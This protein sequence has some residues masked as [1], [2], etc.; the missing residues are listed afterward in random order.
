[1]AGKARDP[2][3]LLNDV[4]EILDLTYRD[5]RFAAEPIQSMT[6]LSRLALSRKSMIFPSLSTYRHKHFHSPRTSMA[7]ISSAI[8]GR[9]RLVRRNSHETSFQESVL[10][11][12]R[13]GSEY[14]AIALPA[15]QR[16][17]LRKDGL[18]GLEV[19]PELV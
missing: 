17:N 11:K 6:A 3:I 13:A 7:A 16:G 1:M 18:R 2:A 9:I 4:V 5:R 15:R 14:S 12:G 8:S 19:M 10:R